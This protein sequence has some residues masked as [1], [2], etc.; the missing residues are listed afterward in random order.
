MIRIIFENGKIL[1]CDHVEKI[2]IEEETFNSV[3][4]HVVGSIK[5][6]KDVRGD[7]KITRS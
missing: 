5:E 4:F 6:E 3:E 1:T 7:D 2:Y